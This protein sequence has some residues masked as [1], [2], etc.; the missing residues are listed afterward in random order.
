MKSTNTESL[1]D[2]V[3]ELDESELTQV[4]GGTALANA[5]ATGKHFDEAKITA[6]I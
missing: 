6:A 1:E 3:I 2:T 5:C 4:A